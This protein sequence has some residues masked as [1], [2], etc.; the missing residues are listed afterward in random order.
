MAAQWHWIVS[1]VENWH[2]FALS[3]Q[4]LAPNL[5]WKQVRGSAMKICCCWNLDN[6]V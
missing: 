4:I 3:V 6:A 1:G 2:L 5:G